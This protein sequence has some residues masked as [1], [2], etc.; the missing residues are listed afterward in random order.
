MKDSRRKLA[1]SLT[2]IV[3]PIIAGVLIVGIFTIGCDSVQQTDYLGSIKGYVYSDT[4][5]TPLIGARVTVVEKTQ[6]VNTGDSGVFIFKDLSMGTSEHKFALLIEY[7]GY[8]NLTF[9]AFCKVGEMTNNGIIY[10]V[11]DTLKILY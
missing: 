2:G 1:S 7:P 6:S 8:R 5:K 4:L 9:L 10:L 11:K 3:L